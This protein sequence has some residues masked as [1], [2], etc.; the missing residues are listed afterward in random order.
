MKKI[1]IPTTVALFC[2]NNMA[3]AQEAIK[4]IEKGLTFTEIVF[5]VAVFVICVSLLIITVTLYVLVKKLVNQKEGEIETQ[6]VE[7]STL[8]FWQKILSLKPI[9]MEK[10]MSLGHSYDGIDELDNPTPPW[11]MFLFYGTIAIAVVYLFVFHVIGDGKVMTTEYAEEIS[12]AQKQNELYMKKF[13]NSI[14]ENNVTLLADSKALT[15]GQE[16]YTKNCVACHGDKGQGGVGPNL[17]DEFWIHGGDFKS[18]YHIISEGVAEKGMIAWK[19]SLN[20]LQ[21]QQVASYLYQF[22]GT[23]PQNG[24]EPQG[25]KYEEK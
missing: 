7:T 19:K 11:F 5:L 22:R 1:A 3:F 18:M 21:I 25:E 13:A 20:P 8:T 9:S 17:T 2:V 23:K 4:P 14:N 24:K 10:Q 12:M 6:S 16:E 15:K